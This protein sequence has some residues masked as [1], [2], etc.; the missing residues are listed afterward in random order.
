[1]P[2]VFNDGG[3][4]GS[5]WKAKNGNQV[6]IALAIATGQEY[7]EVYHQIYR[8][9]VDYVKGLRHGRIKEKGASIPDNGVWPEVSKGYLRDLGW[10]WTPFMGI[11]TGTTVHLTYTEVPDVP[12]MLL[13]VSRSLVA[14][15]NGIVHA[16]NDPSRSGTRAVYGAWTPPA[17]TT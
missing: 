2:W 9:Q 6:I 12:V 3:Y 8:R 14:V 7:R 13:G 16:T 1:M 17:L 11:G 5:G 10:E 4:A 15:V